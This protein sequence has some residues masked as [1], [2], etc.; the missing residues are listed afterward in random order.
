MLTNMVYITGTFRTALK[1]GISD[2]SPVEP[3]TLLTIAGVVM[4]IGNA[5]GSV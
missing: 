1:E 3:V 2:F 4:P 5:T